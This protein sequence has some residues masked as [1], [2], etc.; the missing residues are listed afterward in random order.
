MLFWWLSLNILWSILVTVQTN[1]SLSQTNESISRTIEPDAIDAYV[2]QL[3]T[4]CAFT[5]CDRKLQDFAV[6][7]IILDN[8]SLKVI[9]LSD[10]A[11]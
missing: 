5:P 2:H 11:M 3:L 4:Y 10:T 9:I 1:E 7:D 8:M 6:Q